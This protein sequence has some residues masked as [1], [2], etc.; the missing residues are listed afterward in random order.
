MSKFTR[1]LDQ[2]ASVTSDVITA[3]LAGA[4]GIVVLK[5]L[6]ALIPFVSAFT[7]LLAYPGG[8]ILAAMIYIRARKN[9]TSAPPD[10]FRG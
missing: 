9:L 3:T 2:P 6:F 5:A 10:G 1:Y 8:G 4:A 7:D